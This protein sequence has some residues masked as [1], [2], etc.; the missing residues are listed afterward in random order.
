MNRLD[1]GA[2]GLVH[3]GAFLHTCG[4]RTGSPE[5]AADVPVGA[6]GY[7]RNEMSV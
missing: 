6:R 1:G 4:K 7:A 5:M 2:A 3:A